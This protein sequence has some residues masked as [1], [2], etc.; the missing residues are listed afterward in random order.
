[1]KRFT[2]QKHTLTIA[3]PLLALFSFVVLRSGTIAQVP[4]IT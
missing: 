2:I 1:M 4:V 3:G